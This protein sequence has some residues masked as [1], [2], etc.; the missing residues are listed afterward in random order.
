MIDILEF[1]SVLSELA[2]VK[3]F[4]T[5]LIVLSVLIAI[6]SSF[7]AFGISER[8][9]AAVQKKYKIAWNIFGAITMG[10]GIWSMH[11]IALLALTLPIPVSYNVL[12]T[13]LSTLPAIFSCSVV[14]WLMQEGKYSISRLLLAGLL[15]GLGIGLMH[16]LGMSA[17]VLDAELSYNK[18]L[19]YFSLI[20]AVILAI[21][22]LEVQHQ[23]NGHQHYQFINLKQIASAVV[24]GVAISSMHYT[25]VYAVDFI[26]LK[27][28]RSTVGMMQGNLI[29]LVSFITMMILLV[30]LFT[31]L[32]FR[33][34]KAAIE[35]KRLVSKEQEDILRLRAV[36]NSSFDALVQMNDQGVIIGWSRKAEYIFGWLCDQVIGKKLHE[37]IVPER[38]RKAHSQ[39]LQNFLLTAKGKHVNQILETEALH[40]DG[41]E[42]PIELTVSP[43]KTQHGYEF[44]SFIRDISERKRFEKNQTEL[45]EK[46]SFQKYALDQ[47]A[48]VSITD[49]KGNI[50]YA[51]DKFTAISQYSLEELI[52]ANHR[53]LKSDLHPET[54]FKELWRTIASGCVWQGEICNK[55]KNGSIYWVESTIVPLLDEQG[56][57][58]QY[59][60][61]RTDI[62]RL[63]SFERIQ[64]FLREKAQIRAMISQILQQPISLR[65]RFDKVLRKLCESSLLEIKSKAYVLLLT[66]ETNEP[67][68]FV[69]FG[70]CLSDFANLEKNMEKTLDGQ[71]V[72]DEFLYEEGE[73]EV[74]HTILIRYSEKTFGV[75]NVFTSPDSLIGFS[76]HDLFINI[77]DL[78]GQAIANDRAN[79]ALIKAKED[80]EKASQFKTEFLSNISHE[81]RTPMHGILSFSEI[82][83]EKSEVFSREKLK[84]YFLNIQTSGE[85]LLVLLNDLLDLSKLE[86]GKMELT[87]EQSDLINVFE[88]CYL[89]QEQRMKDLSLSLQFNKPSY[90]VIGNFDTLRIAQVITN[91][92]SNAIKFSSEKGK[93]KVT[94][95][96]NDKNELYFAIEDEGIGIA[97]DE[98]DDIFDAFVQTAKTK[99]YTE[100]TGL[101]LAISKRIIEDHQGIIWA[102]QKITSGS[103]FKF[104]LPAA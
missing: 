38:H 67:Q 39:G 55:A 28:H 100:S 43:I 88:S 85:R 46:I 29:I 76:M 95:D 2:L 61:I 73:D 53:I 4:S 64:G 49:V 83:F 54:F 12:L 14:F 93:I 94:I 51:N 98:L 24:M 77:G 21:I 65:M 80:A 91:L 74:H 104:K 86:A 72:V 58:E 66:E 75:L 30:A 82:G 42:F 92:L 62:T 45:L 25:A 8:Q 70:S 101:G 5:P 33:Y 20:E 60:S 32:L 84:K 41:Y 99:K 48:I 90:P 13:V 9:H 31:P 23:A 102:E 7:T 34:K 96:K 59:V 87:L 44:N 36:I 47:H 3:R 26:P 69:K 35:L 81:L 89:E 40:A 22:S 52:G 11:F 78:L 6:I 19:F 15:L 50:T 16:Y 57:P 37:V 79:K 1:N 71:L 10:L 56:K 63:K 68:L 18:V 27:D 97:Q 103:V 17:M